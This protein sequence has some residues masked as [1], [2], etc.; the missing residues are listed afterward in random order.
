MQAVVSSQQASRPAPASS[1]VTVRA[2]QPVY[3]LLTF[4][5]RNGNFEDYHKAVFTAPDKSELKKIKRDAMAYALFFHDSEDDYAEQEGLDCEK[6]LSKAIRHYKRDGGFNN[7]DGEVMIRDIQVRAIT[8]F[9]YDCF[10]VARR[11]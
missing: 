10:E 11:L 7:C 4:A 9:E 1:S 2:A 3:L 5:V 6:V 8:K